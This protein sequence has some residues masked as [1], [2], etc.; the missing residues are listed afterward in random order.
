MVALFDLD[1]HQFR[2]EAAP[3]RD[4]HAIFRRIHRCCAEQHPSSA[5]RRLMPIWHRVLAA[6]Q[7]DGRFEIGQA[8]VSGPQAGLLH[9]L[10][11]DPHQ[12]RF[13][14]SVERIF[15]DIEARACRQFQQLG[16]FTESFGPIRNDALPRVLGI[17][18]HHRRH[19]GGGIDELPGR[20]HRDPAAEGVADQVIRPVRRHRANDVHIAARRILDG[21]GRRVAEQARRFDADDGRAGWKARAQIEE[22]CRIRARAG[23]TEH[24]VAS[25]GAAADDQ[26]RRVRARFGR[27]ARAIQPRKLHRHGDAQS[28]G[29]IRIHHQ[30]PVIAADRMDA[31]PVAQHRAPSVRGVHRFVGMRREQMHRRFDRFRAIGMRGR[32][33]IVRQR[34]PRLE[35]ARGQILAYP[36]IA[37]GKIDRLAEIGRAVKL[38]QFVVRQS[39][40]LVLDV[41]NQQH[42]PVAEGHLHALSIGLSAVPAV[43]QSHEFDALASRRQR[44]RDLVG[45]HAARRPAGQAVR[46]RRQF[47]EDDL[48]V[49]L[50]K[51]FSGAVAT[52]R[53]PVGPDAV[54][55]DLRIQ[56]PRQPLV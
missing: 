17:H 23:N 8:R 29:A 32:A 42:L 1:D 26:R 10:E 6:E 11:Q 35:F 22:G 25:G 48:R 18:Q 33:Q 54:Q 5:E 39:V 7:F 40:A 24:L 36:T 34:H 51:L 3:R 43:D 15:A 37:L 49:A 46:T 44:T 31:Q 53:L 30:A 13:V 45:Q 27:R 50:G 38:R 41:R 20:L 16:V 55:A 56:M 2:L 4:V 12:R 9:L 14:G 28:P 47:R 52:D 21:D 19:R